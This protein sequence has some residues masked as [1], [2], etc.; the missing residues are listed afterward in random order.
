[1]EQK[2]KPAT[3]W[4]F[5]KNKSFSCT[6]TGVW[7]AVGFC[8][9]CA[10]IFHSPL[11]C[12][13]V[14]SLMD[15]GAQYRMIGDYMKETMDA[16]PLIASNLREK[17]CI[18][19]GA[20]Q[21][22]N[23]I[24]YVMN[25]YKPQCL[26]ISSSCVAGVIGDDVEQEAADAETEYGVPVLCV[27]YGGFLGG[28]YSDGYFQTVR[29]I[30]QRFLRPQEK[31]PGSVLLL[32][33]QMGPWGQY[34]REVKRLLAPFGLKVKWQFPGY[35]PFA[36]WPAM[37][38]A[39]LLIPL[40]YARKNQDGLEE[41]ARDWE[42]KFAISV[43]KDVYPVGWENTCAWLR[44][45]AAF[46]GDAAKGET[47]IE[48]ERK[49][50][51]D[52]VASVISVTKG[53]KAVFGIGRGA[54]WYR[55]G[56][57][58]ETLRRLQLDIT[59]I[60]LYDKL[61]PEDKKIMRAEITKCPAFTDSPATSAEKASAGET[62]ALHTLPNIPIL[63]GEEGQPY[64]ETADILLTTDEILNTAT[65]Q[66]FLPMVPL[67]GTEGQIALMRTIYRVLCRYGAKGGISYV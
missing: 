27:P 24:A 10:V 38:S 60:V 22:R 23:C 65:R 48:A 40:N 1:M 34:A 46:T 19:G 53:K 3:K 67:A 42:D 52:Y 44:K 28:E 35:V 21:L 25:V 55:P 13:H 14:A 31:L 56:E 7:R 33:D 49:R 43:L 66:L 47:V 15:M 51:T 39:S 4:L 50:L 41:I 8:E 63:D 64:I 9:G 62:T 11:G 57:T 20:E 6:M 17:D 58:L 32:G 37:T 12:T 30:T 54:R 59:A 29:L 16:V 18:F 26:V 5:S 61:L 45:I 2:T 36:D